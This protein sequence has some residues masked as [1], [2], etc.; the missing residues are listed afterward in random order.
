M[1]KVIGV[2]FRQA[3][4][5]YY[6]DPLDLDIK[7]GGNVIV[8]TARGVEFGYVVM[9]PKEVEDDKVVQPLKPVMRVATEEDKLAEANNRAKEK[10]AFKTCLQKIRNRNLEM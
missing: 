7:Q 6:F 9:G 10:E 4:K 3:G 1:T 8:E 2:R 5:I